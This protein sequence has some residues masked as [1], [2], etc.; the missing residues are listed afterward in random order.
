MR[1]IEEIRQAA[2]GNIWDIEPMALGVEAYG[3]RA[4]LPD[5]GGC[6]IVIGYNEDNK[7][8]HV[9]IAP[10]KK[11]R[12]PSWED[13]TKL[14]DW[15]FSEDEEAYEMHPKKSQYVNLVGNCL[16]L[17]Q[18]CSGKTLEELINEVEG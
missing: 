14:K 5:C 1:T 17:W 12:M 13:M 6:T 18:P 7:W 3:G 10:I 15:C 16:H 9:S 11:T 4:H 2:G 8:N